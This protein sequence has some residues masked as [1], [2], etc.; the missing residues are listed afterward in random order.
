MSG[1]RLRRLAAALALVFGG[2]AAA[3]AHIGSPDVFFEGH[4]GPYPVLV[5]VQPP[6]VVPGTARVS[7]STDAGVTDVSLRPLYFETGRLGAARP[8]P[9]P[10]QPG[11]PPAGAGGHVFAGQVWLM[12]FGSASVEV[13]VSGARGTGRTVV[14]VPALATARRPMPRGMGAL[15]AL[16]GLALVAGAVA[17]VRAGAVDAV[18]DSSAGAVAPRRGRTVVWVATALVALALALGSRWW[19]AVDSQYRRH[20][21]RPAH[22]TASAD[23]GILHLALEDRGWS[24]RSTGSYLPD[25][26]KLMHLF[27]VRKP[28]GDDA[29]AHLHPAPAGADAFGT[30]LPPLPAGRYRV[31]ADVVREDGM[32]ETLA[33]E[34]TL[35]APAGG[36]RTGPVDPDDSWRTGPVAEGVEQVLADGTT[37]RWERGPAPLVSGQPIAL[38][39]A[40]TA[41]DGGPAVLESYMG[42]YGHAAVLR[43]DASVFVHLHPVGTVS[44]AAQ[45]AFAERMGEDAGMEHAMG[46]GPGAVSFPYSFPRPGRYRVWVQVKR[47][48]A[49]LTGVFDADVG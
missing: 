18:G 25:H 3:R 32:A 33:T 8:D 9:A 17:I 2:P 16:L 29:F 20:L 19:G 48:G 5:Q 36:P 13:T 38:R 39:F 44:M 42:M 31:F 4:A 15:L 35:P 10:L 6:D 37:M 45:G 23:A 14:P 24:E 27:L 22:M 41:P 28:E 49:V 26:G 30:A 1:R 46:S 7:V 43:D 12:E 21:Y 34:A 11:G 47:N 40:V